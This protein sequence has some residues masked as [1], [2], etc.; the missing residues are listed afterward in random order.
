MLVL[1]DLEASRKG[2]GPKLERSWATGKNMLIPSARR[3]VWAGNHQNVAET[4]AGTPFPSSTAEHDIMDRKLE[5]ANPNSRG[6]ILERVGSWGVQ[7]ESP[8]NGRDCGR[9]TISIINYLV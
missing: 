4:V 1:R 3:N 6:V 7:A 8:K 9:S 2:P 5:H